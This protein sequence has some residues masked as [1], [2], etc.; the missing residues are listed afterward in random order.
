MKTPLTFPLMTK[1][2]TNLRYKFFTGY[3][4]TV[5][6]NNS[7]AVYLSLVNNNIKL[8]EYKIA[9]WITVC[10]TEKCLYFAHDFFFSSNKFVDDV[11]YLVFNG[12]LNR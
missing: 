7:G 8:M 10:K 6:K 4:C 12:K 5:E 1:P 3:A 2:T 11:I 9:R